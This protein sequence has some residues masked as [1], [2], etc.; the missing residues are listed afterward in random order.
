MSDS[1]E[2][3]VA[4]KT[5]AKKT[6][7]RVIEPEPKIL[8]RYKILKLLG[9]GAYAFVFKVEDV[10]NENWYALRVIP[11][12]EG[13]TNLPKLIQ[14]EYDVIRKL[15]ESEPND[16][17]LNSIPQ[18]NKKFRIV[19]S[20]AFVNKSYREMFL[21]LRGIEKIDP[22]NMS[23]C[24]LMEYIPGISLKKRFG[25]QE[26][27][28]SRFSDKTLLNMMRQ[29][30]LA[31]NYMHELNLVHRDI[32]LDNVIY[33]KANKRLVIIDYGFSCATTLGLEYTCISNVGTPIYKAPESLK[34]AT[35]IEALTQENNLDVL[36]AADIWA[37]G[38]MF[39]ELL[40]L[41]K[42]YNV[43]NREDLYKM[44][45][46]KKTPKIN[47]DSKLEKIIDSMLTYDYRIRPTALE[48]LTKYFEYK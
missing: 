29:F 17:V 27:I 47:G 33:N 16:L 48:L 30:L 3:K 46:A 43:N 22:T 39:Y 5:T 20:T 26:K 12:V 42:P 25:L 31:I 14:S 28:N 35:K 36:K 40:T 41:E 19:T 13:K 4:G 9:Q 44:I 24:I 6:Q 38:I 32:K 23:T 11:D 2:D 15:H 37:A 7:P 1:R 45:K 34:K 21:S 10:F 18:Y 8:G